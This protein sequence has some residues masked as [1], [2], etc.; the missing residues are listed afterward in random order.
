MGSIFLAL[1]RSPTFAHSLDMLNYVI[2]LLF[3]AIYFL[4]GC[5]DKS[6]NKTTIKGPSASANA[7]KDL[8]GSGT[9]GSSP[10]QL[11]RN[12]ILKD[13]AQ[14]KNSGKFVLNQEKY[15]RYFLSDSTKAVH[16]HLLSSSETVEVD[17]E[18]M[19]YKISMYVDTS[20]KF[21]IHISYKK[22]TSSESSSSESPNYVWTQ[23]T[24][25]YISATEEG[26]SAK[27]IEFS[28]NDDSNGISEFIMSAKLTLDDQG[29]P[30]FSVKF[31]KAI[32]LRTQ[33]S[34]LELNIKDK[35]FILD[36]R[37]EK[38]DAQLKTLIENQLGQK[39]QENLRK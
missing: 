7:G 15:F 37:P 9:R 39:R 21:Y 26:K 38:I 2:V 33:S 27:N 11:D 6:G 36:Y 12:Q 34:K 24:W 10:D 17:K 19:N 3:I 8:S 30:K 4:S 5:G 35:I 31:D 16:R 23:G 1:L 20:K 29:N 28:A 18:K 32:T 25:N 14:E 13:I 22:E